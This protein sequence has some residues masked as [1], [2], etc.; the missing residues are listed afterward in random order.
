M[1]IYKSIRAALAGTYL[2]D[3]KLAKAL[4]ASPATFDDRLISFLTGLGQ[5]VETPANTSI[6]GADIKAALA[7]LDSTSNSN[8]VTLL[9]NLRYIDSESIPY[10]TLSAIALDAGG[11]NNPLSPS[12]FK[13][14][15]HR[16]SEFL[17]SLSVTA[18][19][20]AATF[21]TPVRY[22]LSTAQAQAPLFYEFLSQATSLGSPGNACSGVAA[23]SFPSKP[24][25][26]IASI[27]M[28]GTS[29]LVISAAH[30]PATK[31]IIGEPCDFSC[32][33]DFDLTP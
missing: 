29:Y 13:A 14:R 23:Y 28:I 25:N 2:G 6:S 4:F 31:F 17:W 24:F 26:P 11:V 27:S 1:P 16:R 9:Q 10:Q 8:R 20:P 30:A 18:E 32:N 3:T 19:F 21:S 22:A 7:A 15:I 12:F 33:L 5:A